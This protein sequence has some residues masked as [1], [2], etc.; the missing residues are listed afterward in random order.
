MTKDRGH[1]PVGASSRYR[2]RNCAG[3][4]NLCKRL[5][6]APESSY[7]M[8]GTKAHE[9]AAYY[10]E[11]QRW[12]KDSPPDMIEHLSVYTDDV[13]ET[14][15]SVDQS[16]KGNRLLIEHGFDLSQLHKDA[17][18]TAD[19][20]IY[21]AKTKT[22]YVYDLKYGSGILVEADD[23]EQ[24]IYYAVGAFLSLDLAVEDVVL[25]IA[26]PRIEHESGYIREHKFKA[27]RL[28]SEATAIEEEIKRTDDPDA[29]LKAGS[30]CRFCP[31]LGTPCPEAAKN[32]MS[33]AK[34][35]FAPSVS[36]D[37]KVLADTLDKLPMIEAFASQV[38]E[39]A[40]GEA[41][42]GRVPPNYKLV[43]K[44][45]TRKWKAEGQGVG[46]FLSKVLRDSKEIAACYTTPELKSPAQIEKIVPKNSKEQLAKF[47]EAVSSGE[48]LVHISEPGEP[49]LLDAKSVF[50][51]PAD[52]DDC[53]SFF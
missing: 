51:E 33:V 15:A 50:G 18:G 40:Y 4:V 52:D 5:P 13:L 35:I 7:A 30:W 47:V 20:V 3:S 24:L 31:A 6:P 11:N 23:N 25:R 1:S 9:L 19:C 36:Y 46:K 48:K 17:W 2:W 37:P 34:K 16:I 45:A 53:N 14:W 38:R 44:R 39:F 26:Q 22:L 8:E 43:K 27:D 32:A 49:I 10:L 29:P 28:L 42:K 41:L 12:P 21:D